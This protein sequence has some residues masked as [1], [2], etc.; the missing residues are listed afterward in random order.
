MH[1]LVFAFAVLTALAPGARGAHFSFS[2]T[3]DGAGTSCFDPPGSF[4]AIN[5]LYVG[6]TNFGLPGGGVTGAEFSLRGLGGLI[7][8][9]PVGSYIFN[10]TSNP[11]ASV[12]LGDPLGGGANIA[13]A[14]CQ[15]GSFVW[16]YSFQF[17]NFGDTELRQLHVA[18]RQ[19]PTNS[20]FDCPLV[21]LCNAPIFTAMCVGAG[22]AFLNILRVPP[23]PTNPLPADGATGVPLNVTLQ[24]YVPP[25]QIE[26]CE[27]GTIWE[28]IYF[29][30]V[31]DPPYVNSDLGDRRY[32]VPQA[33]L[34]NTRYYW[35]VTAGPNS[36]PVW[37]F[38]TAT[39]VNVAVRPSTWTQVRN[40]YR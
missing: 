38:T 17:I 7:G 8:M 21:V 1:P 27:P 35:R 26:T 36:S 6:V 9:P 25:I 20:N 29:G 16:L 31:P 37:S 5:T 24:W 19:P 3:P 15:T 40:L 12:A 28:N 4:P 14:S 39:D 2:S 18:A 32:V 33:L 23:A 10:A 22:S 30:T 13:F 34:P 11:D